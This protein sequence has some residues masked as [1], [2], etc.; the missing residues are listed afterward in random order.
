MTDF[1]TIGVRWDGRG[2]KKGEA[3]MDKFARKGE[4]TE[5]RV[6]KSSVG[7]AG[8]MNMVGRSA[9]RMAATLGAALAAFLGG[10]MFLGAIREQ[11]Q[12]QR[13][14][15]KTQAI[16]T[17]TGGAAG[18][19]SAQLH[20][21][22]R[23]LARATLQ[24]TEGIMK[25]QQVML[26]FR[27][28]TGETFDRA[29][30]AATDLSEAI[31]TDLN[32]AVLQI[33]KALEDPVT[34]MTAL[35][36]SGT[37]FT[38]VQ[39]DMVKEMVRV[40]D[41]AGA[42]AFILGEL[43]K[44]Y[45]GVA[46]AAAAGLAGVMDGL[47]QSFQEFNIALAD[48]FG[49]GVTAVRMLSGL[50]RGFDFLTENIDDV[51]AGLNI[52][53]IPLKVATGLV[54]ALGIAVVQAVRLL[55]SAFNAMSDYF[56]GT[57]N[58]QTELQIATDNAVLAMADEITQSQLLS[59]ALGENTNVSVVAA[60]AKLKEALMRQEN[61]KAII[62]ENRALALASNE[63]G[64]LLA[65]MTDTTAALNSIGFAGRNAGS[66]A[67]ADA[68]EMLE[69]RLAGL[70]VE[71]MRL[72]SVDSEM[73]DQLMLTTDNIDKLETALAGAEDGMVAFGDEI[74][75]P[76]ELA[77]RLKVSAGATVDAIETLGDK[78]K[79]L[80]KDALSSLG[81]AFED[82]VS[83]GFSD[84][85]GFV[86]SVWDI[87][88]KL[89]FDMI[90]LAAKNQIM[91]SLGMTGAGAAGGA[92][93]GGGLLSGAL[94]AFA[95]AG[96][97]AGTG[98]LGGLGASLGIGGAAGGGIFG[99]GA[100]AA[101]AG[102][103]LMATIGAALP[104][105][106]IGL[107]IFSLFKKKPAISAKDFAAIQTGLELSGMALFDTGKAGKKMAADL[108][109]SFNSIEDFTKATESY[110]T[111][112][113]TEEEKRQKAIDGLAGVFDEL[114]MAVPA[115]ASAFREIVEAQ[116]LTT[117]SGRDTYAA[118]LQVSE[119]FA[120]V[121]GGVN[122][123]TKALTAL[124]ASV[125]GSIFSTLVDERRAAA[126][127][128]N[129]IAFDVSQPDR[130]GGGIAY[131]G[132]GP[133]VFARPETEAERLAREA[134]EEAAA[135]TSLLVSIYKNSKRSLAITD[136]WEVVGLPPERTT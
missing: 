83:R 49:L 116:D 47:G 82:F 36:R 9:T 44:Q 50:S 108:L 65:D 6:K 79:D 84:F 19:S 92:A 130:A 35:T 21:D 12:L 15:L 103:G 40:G 3:G 25:A 64:N 30:I 121:Y 60:S 2:L 43:E 24:S 42:Q 127:L 123:V 95:T 128:Q 98:L 100:S 102:G 80:G 109:K 85:K 132:T 1:A 134:A 33:S 120:A 41:T 8:A 39:K 66:A 45:G 111:N 107:A 56:S 133:R 59:T 28:I 70:R 29:I 72:L 124:N 4:Q 90:A 126:Y 106:G 131:R 7:M 20:E 86:S 76:I 68:F 5:R 74:I 114:G 22:A 97:A 94:G 26:T 87:F 129:G 61:V 54:V 37:V 62:S 10:K 51:A 91:I 96:G 16:I 11:E 34:G 81:Q 125:G 136:Q 105:L 58:G 118:L 93:G 17:A 55:G 67:T 14:M 115:T 119:A 71:Q 75:T 57:I 122:D 69:V 38:Q 78:L 23:A 18:R 104:L 117:A 88:K 77:D 135:Q 46:V 48:G 101:V 73:S 112:F 89:I 31:G 53:L 99:I 52:L 113:F 27:H 110:Y 32:S 63:Y 13:N